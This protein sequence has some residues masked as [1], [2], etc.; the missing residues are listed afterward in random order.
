MTVVAQRTFLEA[1]AASPGIEDVRRRILSWVVGK[2]LAAELE[3]AERAVLD[4]PAGSLDQKVAIKYSWRIEG[5]A[6]LAWA[7][8]L[9]E[10]PAYDMPAD[11]DLLTKNLAIAGDGISDLISSAQ[12]R[13][14]EQLLV[15]ANQ[16]FSLHWR[17]VNFRLHPQKMDFATFAREAWFGPL[18]IS[19]LRLV[20]NDLALG[21]AEIAGASQEMFDLCSDIGMERH[22]A[23]NWLTGD[24]VVYSKVDI[25]T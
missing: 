23:A 13:D 14:Y 6:V 17:L 24:H 10:L 15:F 18:D 3:D 21:E 16:M 9:Y 11:P 19:T 1:H 25:S 20:D 22:R 12:L 5:A 2:G 7:I 4:A 8:G